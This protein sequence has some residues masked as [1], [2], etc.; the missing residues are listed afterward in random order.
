MVAKPHRLEDAALAIERCLESFLSD[1]PDGQVRIEESE[2][3]HLNVTVGSDL[4]QGRAEDERADLV[5]KHLRENLPPTHFGEIARV[6]VL[7]RAE[8]DGLLA[9]D[10]WT[11]RTA[12]GTENDFG[13]RPLAEE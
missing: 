11:N 4:F 12:G 9:I 3:G 5:W 7:T 1:Q 6:T 2:W 8:Y 13:N 10:R